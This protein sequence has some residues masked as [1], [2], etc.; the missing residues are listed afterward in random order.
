[1][2]LKAMAVVSVPWEGLTFG[3]VE[4]FERADS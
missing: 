1:M 3:G 2:S 4:G